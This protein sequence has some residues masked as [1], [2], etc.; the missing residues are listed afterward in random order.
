MTCTSSDNY[1]RHR[2]PSRHSRPHHLLPAST[3]GSVRGASER[4]DQGRPPL[5]P[6]PPS[7]RW[8][9]RRRASRFGVFVV[10]SIVLV[11]IMA[12]VAPDAALNSPWLPLLVA[13]PQIAQGGLWLVARRRA[14]G[15]TGT[16][17]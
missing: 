14:P 6:F 3:T 17:G 5:I 2:W 16:T 1:P 12:L 8:G 9:L 11:G 10:T 13:G 4:K 15:S 7:T